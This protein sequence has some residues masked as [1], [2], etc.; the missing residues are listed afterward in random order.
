MK[1]IAA[2]LLMLLSSFSRADCVDEIFD[3]VDANKRVSMGF[4]EGCYKGELILSYT[5][6]QQQKTTDG[7]FEHFASVP[8]KQ[9]CPQQKL[10]GEFIE[11]FSCRKDGESPLAGAH[12][13]IKRY[14]DQIECDGT[15]EPVEKAIYV[16]VAG[17]TDKTPKQLL[18]PHSGGSC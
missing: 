12:Y 16:C 8:F 18:L 9:E 13:K 14:A 2:T 15:V 11:E 7:S 3:Y 6:P 1:F 5:L 4:A 10:N 17:C